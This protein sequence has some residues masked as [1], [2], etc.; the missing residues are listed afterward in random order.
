MV[1][2]PEPY[3]TL[4]RIRGRER[5]AQAGEGAGTAFVGWP[6]DPNQAT[7][8]PLVIAETARRAAEGAAR[9]GSGR[10]CK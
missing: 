2:A 9:P 4:N 7:H 5:G 6:E 3:T 8:D 10:G 1:H